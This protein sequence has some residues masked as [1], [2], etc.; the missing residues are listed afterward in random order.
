MNTSWLLSMETLAQNFCESKNLK[1]NYDRYRLLQI[2]AVY[3]GLVLGKNNAKSS[4]S[5]LRR[6]MTLR[7]Y[8]LYGVPFSILVAMS[9]IC[10]YNAIMHVNC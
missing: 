6:S 3:A 1:I 9:L 7:E 8:V 4:V 10:T 5:G 2:Y